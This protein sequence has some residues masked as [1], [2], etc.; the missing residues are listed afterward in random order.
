MTDSF[1]IAAL[2]FFLSRFIDTYRF[3]SLSTMRRDDSS[4][5]SEE[6]GEAYY[7]GGSERGA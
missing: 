2:L 4:A 5:S 6:E 7:A 3:A 1:D